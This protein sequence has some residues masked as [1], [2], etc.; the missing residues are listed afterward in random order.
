MS[1]KYLY[2]KLDGLEIDIL[3][4]T[5]TVEFEKNLV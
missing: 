2:D 4:L 3:D 5:F 1:S